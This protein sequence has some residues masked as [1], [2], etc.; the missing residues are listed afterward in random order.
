MAF[1]SGSK[2]KYAST[3]LSADFTG[4]MQ[5]DEKKSNSGVY[6]FRVWHKLY[7]LGVRMKS[8]ILAEDV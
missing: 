7:F 6:P 3:V 8:R 4:H 5:T 2:L 1:K